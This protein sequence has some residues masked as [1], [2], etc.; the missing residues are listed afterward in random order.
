MDHANVGRMARIMALA[1]TM[2][3]PCQVFVNW[4][5]HVQEIEVVICPRGWKPGT[6]VDGEIVHEE[7]SRLEFRSW[8]WEPAE[9][10][11]KKLLEIEE[12]LTSFA[13]RGVL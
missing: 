6:E 3:A 5:G 12:T 7:G 8:N 11:E 9:E 1:A 2:P 4:S 10:I 13:L